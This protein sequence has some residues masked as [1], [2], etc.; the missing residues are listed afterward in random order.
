LSPVPKFRKWLEEKIHQNDDHGK[1]FD[2]S[3][4]SK[5]EWALL[6]EAGLVQHGDPWSSFLTC[7][8][9]AN[10]SEAAD[11]EHIAILRPILT[12]LAARYILLEKHRGKPLDGV[13]R[14]HLGNGAIVHRINF[15]ADLSRKGI[16]NSFGIMMNY[17]YDLDAL[18]DNQRA[19]EASYYIQASGDVIQLLPSESFPRQ[20][21]L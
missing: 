7:L 3:V 16:Q 18:E 2:G 9:G 10:F 21:K 8:E 14:F 17:R 19:F 15:G 4:L 20:S 13:A 11:P 5:D 12:K 6:S 1:F